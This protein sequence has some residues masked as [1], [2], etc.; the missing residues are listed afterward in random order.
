[1]DVIEMEVVQKRLLV[2]LLEWACQKIELTETQAT[3]AAERYNTIGEWLGDRE[4]PLLAEATIYAQGSVRLRTTVR[5]VRRLEHD[6]DLICALP[7]TGP[8]LPVADVH[9]LVGDR[10]REHATYRAML[11]PINRGWR[12]N[13]ANEFHLD[14]TPAVPDSA[15]GNGAILVPDRALRTWKESNPKGYATWFDA[16]AA[17]EV[18][19]VPQYRR[20]LRAD[21]EPLPED[22]PFRGALRRIVQ[23]MKR[24]RDNVYLGK[25]ASELCNAPISIII[26]TLASQAFQRVARQVVYADEFDLLQAVVRTMP[27]FVARGADRNLWVPNPVNPYENF[28]EKWSVH[29][30][31]AKAFID[32]HAR[33]QADA[34]ALAA[35]RGLDEVKRLLGRMLGDDTA[36]TVLKEYT[37]RVS[38]NRGVGGLTV[39]KSTSGAIGV[40][41][42]TAA[43]PAIRANTFF[44]SE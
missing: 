24:H 21:V 37:D 1:M 10:L 40:A 36:V 8:E 38:S 18:L 14:I 6:I 29:P 39:A 30:E 4:H 5:P 15:V 34:D 43:S 19:R 13:Y 25:P 12:L 17:I 33:F 7:H 2:G 28:A 9:R 11:E 31:R 3:L 32:W 23:V 22:V 27:A 44:G 41:A 35:A 20:V 26:T 42:A 16:I